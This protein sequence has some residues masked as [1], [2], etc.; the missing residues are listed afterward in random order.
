MAS[1]DYELAID[2]DDIPD[3]V[4]TTDATAVMIWA[5][6]QGLVDLNNAKVYDVKLLH[7]KPID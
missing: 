4:D 1:F 6:E 3:T 2:A 5:R 7:V